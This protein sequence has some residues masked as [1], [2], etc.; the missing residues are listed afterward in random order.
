MDQCL[1]R[2]C[3]G[4]VLPFPDNLQQQSMDRN[5]NEVAKNCLSLKD[6]DDRHDE[7]VPSIGHSL[8]LDPGVV[9]RTSFQIML[10]QSL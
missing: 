7:N 1:A 10:E 4:G 5:L 3:R 2:R 6:N 8:L 9:L